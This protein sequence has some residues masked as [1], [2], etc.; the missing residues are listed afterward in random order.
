MQRVIITTLCATFVA[1]AGAP[2]MAEDAAGTA[3]GSSK[4]PAAPVDPTNAEPDEITGTLVQEGPPEAT[5][6]LGEPIPV[7]LS[8]VHPPDV[9]V[10][11]PDSFGTGRWELLSSNVRTIEAEKEWTTI[12]ELE[13][14]VFRPGQ[15]TLEPFEIDLIGRNSDGEVRSEPITVKVLSSLDDV[16][17][18]PSFAAPRPPVEVWVEDNSVYLAAGFGAVSLL[19]GLFFFWY[20]RRDDHLEPAVPPRPPHEVA[21]ERLGRLAA[22]D[23]VERGQHMIFYVRLSETIREYLGRRYGFKGVEMTTTEILEALERADVS[24][25]PSVSREDIAEFLLHCDAVKFGGQIPSAQ[26]AS[27]KLR[28]AF[29][30]VESTRPT[31]VVAEA[32]SE[33]RQDDPTQSES[34]PATGA[35]NEDD[36]W[37]PEPEDSEDSEKPED[38]EKTEDSDT[39]DLADATD[40]DVVDDPSPLS[41]ENEVPATV[42]A[43]EPTN[44]EEMTDGGVQDEIEESPVEEPPVEAPP[45]LEREREDG[46]EERDGE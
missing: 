37:R 34:T 36:R 31:P 28:R 30:F 39:A 25:P 42:E 21:L 46:E 6:L 38:S 10:L 43:P 8:I 33:P 2:A 9:D 7:T 23:L 4:S 17:G 1:L 5:A 44:V 24:W 22:D 32:D 35:T 14:G 40:V 20:R 12:M 18:E 11:L 19:F 13:F 3:P 26:T 45:T 29:A 15:T 27:E 16:E 41:V